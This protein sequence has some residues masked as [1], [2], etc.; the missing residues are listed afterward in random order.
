MVELV[1]AVANPR[2]GICL[3]RIQVGPFKVRIDQLDDRLEVAG[4][5]PLIGA[6][7]QGRVCR[8]PVDD[9][10]R[11]NW[12]PVE[13]LSDPSRADDANRG[14]RPLKRA[15][16]AVSAQLDI[17]VVTATPSVQEF[18][19]DLSIGPDRR[20][21]GVDA[22]VSR[23]ASRNA[24]IRAAWRSIA[25]LVLYATGAIR[26]DRCHGPAVRPTWLTGRQPTPPWAAPCRLSHEL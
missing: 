20:G 14:A 18:R 7:Y 19:R 12:A 21:P 10:P 26:Q 6:P 3:T 5:V 25:D 1:P 17:D 24:E 11:R 2:L 15:G 22:A 4:C 8:P 13:S 23:S 9:T 16:V